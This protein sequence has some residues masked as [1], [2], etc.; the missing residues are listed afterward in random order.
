MTPSGRAAR[1]GTND[2]DDQEQADD[3]QGGQPGVEESDIWAP[4]S[5]DDYDRIK[6][7][8]G[9]TSLPK[10]FSGGLEDIT[11][12]LLRRRL[13]AFAVRFSGGDKEHGYDP[14]RFADLVKRTARLNRWV[15]N[16]VAPGEVTY[17]GL[18][19]SLPGS[20]VAHFAVSPHE[21][22][23]RLGKERTYPSIYGARAVARLLAATGDDEVLLESVK[24]LGKRAV[25]TY[26]ATLNDAVTF[27]LSIGWLTREG[28][29]STVSPK[30]A[31]KGIA[32]LD[33]VPRMIKH[34][35]RVAGYIDRPVA[36]TGKV[37]L[38]PLKGG[39][40][41]LNY[42]DRLQ[43]QIRAAWGRYVDAT[44][45]VAEPE[46]PSLPRAPRRERTLRRIHHVYDSPD[47]L[48]EL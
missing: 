31:E 11:R 40:M 3:E 46:N 5:D 30:R 42:P 13:A 25:T 9:L 2:D 36:Q 23:L 18:L 41:I 32:A 16:S 12:E 4:P 7:F 44:I 35:E 8:Q 33:I 22:R 21:E 1:S 28:Q 45:V 39:P 14:I 37:R 48:P 24:P 15:S 27:E 34:E 43:E 38:Q 10:Q 19:A 20:L 26:L 17:P 47:D 29:F 6:F